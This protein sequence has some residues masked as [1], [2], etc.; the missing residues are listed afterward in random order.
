MDT[1]QQQPMLLFKKVDEPDAK[2]DNLCAR[3]ITLT[4]LAT[5]QPQNDWPNKTSQ[6]LD[7]EITT[8]DWQQVKQLFKMHIPRKLKKRIK[9]QLADLYIAMGVKQKKVTATINEIINLQVKIKQKYHY[10]THRKH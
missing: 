1:K 3:T 5:E 7:Y 4:E 9:K 10:E 8:Q 6:T 2:W